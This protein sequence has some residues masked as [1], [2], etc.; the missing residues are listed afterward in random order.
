MAELSREDLFIALDL[1]MDANE[2]CDTHSVATVYC[3]LTGKLHCCTTA[4]EQATNS[5]RR[6]G[7]L[8]LPA[9]EPR[10]VALDYSNKYQKI[11]SDRQAEDED[12]LEMEASG[13]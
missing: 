10:C 8:T 5:K 7:Q 4:A 2:R 12:R 3:A 9:N 13:P 6:G 11:R 1:M